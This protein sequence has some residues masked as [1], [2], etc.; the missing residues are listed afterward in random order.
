METP[1]QSQQQRSPL[2]LAALV[3][4][5]TDRFSAEAQRLNETPSDETSRTG[6]GKWIEKAGKSAAFWVKKPTC[7]RYFYWNYSQK[8]K[9]A[10]IRFCARGSHG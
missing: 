6:W 2:P 4:C 1:K 7:G 5:P 10:T 9:L 3:N 8:S